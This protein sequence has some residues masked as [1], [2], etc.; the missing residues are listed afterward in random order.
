MNIINIEKNLHYQNQ[1]GQ[2]LKDFIIANDPEFWKIISNWS[3]IKYYI[4]AGKKDGESYDKDLGKC[5]DYVKEY[6]DLEE[7][8]SINEAME[9]L[10]RIKDEFEAW[11]G[12]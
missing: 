6:V 11:K 10:E 8:V 1:H 4:R 12:E 3:A 9:V 5:K 7:G 2:Q